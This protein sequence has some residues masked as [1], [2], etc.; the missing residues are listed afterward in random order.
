MLSQQPNHDQNRPAA[1]ADPAPSP[2]AGSPPPAAQV[3]I[4]AEAA[5]TFARARLDLPAVLASVAEHLATTIGDGC[6]IRLLSD[7]GQCLRTV[8]CLG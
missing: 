1:G 2:A 4:L 3:Q 7:D 8:G 5:H 6:L